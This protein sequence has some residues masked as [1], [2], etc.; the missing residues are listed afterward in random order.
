MGKLAGKIIFV[1]AVVF[2]GYLLI[3]GRVYIAWERVIIYIV[4]AVGIAVVGGIQSMNQ[5]KQDR[6]HLKQQ[7]GAQV[8]TQ[9]QGDALWKNVNPTDAQGDGSAVSGG[10]DMPVQGV[11]RTPAGLMGI[12]KFLV[13][14]IWLMLLSI[15]ALAAADDAFSDPETVGSFAALLGGAAVFTA[16]FVWFINE[17]C[18][19]IYYTD[20]EVTVKKG[21]R[22]TCYAW[23]EIGE[24]GQRGYMCSFRDREGKRIFR[25]NCS[26]EGFDGF[27]AQY[28]RTHTG[29]N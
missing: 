27:I 6:D 24:Y 18:C 29:L 8:Q 11:V 12:I 1:I 13:I 17:F 15:T 28:R 4:F 3:S 21:R 16:A 19:V 2:L 9:A 10:A 14:F 26:Y 7:P 5:K 23:R 22:E 25:T 20:T